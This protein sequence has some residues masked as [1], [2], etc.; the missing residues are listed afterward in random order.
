MYGSTHLKAKKKRHFWSEI[1]GFSGKIKVSFCGNLKYPK[2]ASEE[3]F[4]LLSC[5]SPAM[6]KYLILVH[7]SS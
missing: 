2:I 5:L 1:M 3:G 6:Y 4:E 7:F